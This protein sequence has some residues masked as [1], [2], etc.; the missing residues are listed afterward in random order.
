[1]KITD[2]SREILHMDGLDR[3]ERA[4]RSCYKSEDKIRC[5]VEDGEWPSHCTGFI[6]GCDN[7]YCS[8]HSS[9]KFVRQLIKRGHEA[10][11][12]HGS[13]TVKFITNRGVTQ[14]LVRH[15]IAA[16]GQE[17]T[18]YVNYGGKETE[19]IRPVWCLDNILGVW[20]DGRMQ[21]EAEYAPFILA[22]YGS[23][24]SYQDLIEEG[25]RPEQAREVLPNAL[26]TEIVVTANY[27]EWRHIFKLRA[28]GTT[29][30][31]HPQMQALMLPVLEEF[32]AKLPAMFEDLNL[33]STY[34]DQEVGTLHRSVLSVHC[35]RGGSMIEMI[36]ISVQVKV[37][38][39]RA[40][41]VNDGVRE[42]WI[43]KSQI[44]TGVDDGC[45]D[46]NGKVYTVEMSEWLAKEKGFI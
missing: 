16:F 44:D 18:W 32:K 21:E 10:M 11:L 20:D 2:Q 5:T 34:Q 6:Y 25:W 8:T 29:G 31:P 7:G 9:S 30:K 36:G 23:A 35:K 22:C 14:E 45:Y 19:F 26:K 27:R 17:S 12:E 42:A 33:R 41:L 37:E 15:R 38:T 46:L 3:I 13:A 24:R 4:G 40:L 39:D 1:M 43:P 28:L